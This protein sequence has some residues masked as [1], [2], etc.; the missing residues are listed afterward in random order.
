MKKYIKTAI[1]L[2]LICAVAAVLLAVVNSVT[3][4]YIAAYES[5]KVTKALEEVS[6]GFDIGEKALVENGYVS[7]M[8][9][10][11]SNGKVVGY[12]LELAT[13]GYAGDISLLAGYGLDGSVTE[14]K[15]VSDSETP[16]VGKKAHNEGYMDKF[17]GKGSSTDNPIPTTKGMLSE[18]DSLVVS[19]ATMTFTGISTALKAGSDYVKSLGEGSR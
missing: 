13:R 9:T 5:E 14:V 7:S 19:G 2:A 18:A 6:S 10:L 15:I 3:E 8:Y 11:L 1:V 17:I 12:I 4:P 16:G